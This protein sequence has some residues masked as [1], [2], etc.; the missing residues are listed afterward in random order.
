[1]TLFFQRI[2]SSLICASL[3]STQASAQY[4]QN[5]GFL[6]D[7]NFDKASGSEFISGNTPGTVL[8]KVNLWGGV[9]RPGIHHVPVKTDLMSLLSY[10][11]GPN[12]KADLEDVTI[13]RDMGDKQ[14]LIEVN[15]DK[16]LSGS[17][18]HRVELAPNDIVVVPQSEPLISQDTLGVIAIISVVISTAVAFSVID[19]NNRIARD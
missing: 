13:K 9:N 5:A 14:E 2:F 19:R 12:S 10:A 6:K 17:S 4:G 11:G 7:I 1:M 3:I 16:L 18:H 15:V 8:M